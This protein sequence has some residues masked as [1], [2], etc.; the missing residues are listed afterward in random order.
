[1]S[2]EI[3]ADARLEPVDE[4]PVVAVLVFRQIASQGGVVALVLVESPATLVE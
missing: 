3:L 1:M 4:L 2:E